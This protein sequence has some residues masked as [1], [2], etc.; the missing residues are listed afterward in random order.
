MQGHSDVG[1]SGD[2]MSGQQ[3]ERDEVLGL[4]LEFLAEMDEGEG[5]ES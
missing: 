4:V 3:A 2:I 1:I 5:E